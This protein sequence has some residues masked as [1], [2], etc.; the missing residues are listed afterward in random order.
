[1]LETCNACVNFRRGGRKKILPRF[2]FAK[3]Y[4]RS[5]E[6]AF[7]C[8]SRLEITK[9]DSFLEEMC[10]TED[11]KKLGRDLIVLKSE[12]CVCVCVLFVCVREKER[13]RIRV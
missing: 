12:E 10:I 2:F 11:E 8:F 3:C 4:F 5:F 1:M 9:L 7:C 6:N 13:E